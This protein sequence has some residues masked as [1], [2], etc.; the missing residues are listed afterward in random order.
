MS[1]TSPRKQLIDDSLPLAVQ[2]TKER[3]LR[4][5]AEQNYALLQ[6]ESEDLSQSLFEEAN[7]MV[8]AER[9]LNHQVTEKLK[10]LADREEERTARLRHLEGAMERIL[11]VRGVLAAS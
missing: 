3:Q 1:P 10:M 6:Q 5:Q 8:A 4:M 7:K 2:L 9:K 11:R